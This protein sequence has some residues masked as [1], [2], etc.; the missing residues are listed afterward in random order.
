MDLHQ[1]IQE[2]LRE[3]V[4]NR[5]TS[6]VAALRFVLSMIRNEEIA[7]RRD[8]EEQEMIGVIQR[9][10][11]KREESIR[12]YG[13]AARSDL[14]QKEMEEREILRTYLPAPLNEEELE[15]LIQEALKT[16]QITS[17]KEIGKVMKIVMADARGRVDGRRVE[18]KVKALLTSP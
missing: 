9:E 12:I 3:A 11:K 7:K 16:S 2:D 5:A 1:R 17:V 18:E 13:Q 15:K 6:R 14:V 8:L 4:K 10:V